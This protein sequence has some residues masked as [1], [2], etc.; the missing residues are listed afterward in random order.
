MNG[1]GEELEEFDWENV[2]DEALLEQARVASASIAFDRLTATSLEVRAAIKH[3][4]A[5]C[6]AFERIKNSLGE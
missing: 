2:D 1:A 3:S 6:Q 4:H 5:S